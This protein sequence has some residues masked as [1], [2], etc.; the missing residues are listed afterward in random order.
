[1]AAIVRN[2]DH[3]GQGVGARARGADAVREVV[4]VAA[5][6]RERHDQGVR[7]QGT[8]AVEGFE[9]VGGGL[10]VVSGDTKSLDVIRVVIGHEEHDPQGAGDTVS[11]HGVTL[12]EVRTTRSGEDAGRE[13]PRA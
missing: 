5:R 11:C 12:S 9:G 10:D 4:T 1:V 7:P 2:Q 3:H 6:Q 13:A 8:S